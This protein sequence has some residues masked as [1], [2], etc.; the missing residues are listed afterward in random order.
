MLWYI[1]GGIVT[2]AVVYYVYTRYPT[3]FGK[4]IEEAGKIED[5]VKDQI[6]KS[7]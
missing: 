7:N 3:W 6:N 5:Q 2:L 4:A 1:L